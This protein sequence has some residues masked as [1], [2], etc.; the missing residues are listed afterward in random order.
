MKHEIIE[1]SR[2]KEIMK[3]AIV[4]VFEERKEVLSDLLMEALED[5]ALIRAIKEGEK[6]E[7]VSRQKVFN[8]LEGKA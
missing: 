4:E 7:S 5:L 2:L 6:T 8:I 1:E 3:T